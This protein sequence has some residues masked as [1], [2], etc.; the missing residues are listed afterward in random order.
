MCAEI[1]EYYP[2]PEH[3]LQYSVPFMETHEVL[4]LRVNKDEAVVGFV[5]HSAELEGILKDY[6]KPRRIRAVE[7]GKRDFSIHLARLVSSRQLGEG[8]D[9]RGSSSLSLDKIAGDAPIVNLVNS[10]IMEGIQQRASDIHI[11]LFEEETIV[12]YRIDGYLQVVR[13]LSGENFPLISS[14]VKIMSDLNIMEKRLPQDGRLSVVLGSDTADLRV[15][16]IPISG[17]GESIVMRI[18]GRTEK[19]RSFEELGFE[20][21]QKDEL[22]ELAA[23]PNGLVL[24]TGPTGCGKTTTLNSLLEEIKS[25]EKKIISIEDPVEYVIRGVDQIQT[26]D[27]IG[28]SF[29]TLLRRV[30]RQDPNII[31]VGE[32]RDAETAELAVRSALTGHLV[33]ST[34]HTNDAISV[35]PRLINMGIEPYLLSS[36]LK[37]STAQRLVRRICPHCRRE[38]ELHQTEKDLFLRN[39]ME[40][41]AHLYQA[42]GCPRCSRTG[43]L[44]RTVISETVSVNRELEELIESDVSRS[45]YADFLRG[46]KIP[47]LMHDGLLKAARGLTTLEETAM[48]VRYL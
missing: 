43:Y 29:S 22:L 45:R 26:N 10:I 48:A 31:L 12:R 5:N 47:G 38:R 44:G 32:I 19:P 16:I 24:V 42:E 39:G 18:L 3:D 27:E 6:H 17:E 25:F 35:I 33:L 30:L 2:I 21:T 23:H 9:P 41:P 36:V 1:R 20:E 40:A 37:G 7:I 15:S 11:E 4:L 8:G 13:Q 28:L 14:R 34:L 46:K